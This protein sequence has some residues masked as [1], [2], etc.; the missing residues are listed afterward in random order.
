M[1]SSEIQRLFPLSLSTKDSEQ[2]QKQ[3]YVLSETPLIVVLWAEFLATFIS[4]TGAVGISL[5]FPFANLSTVAV[6]SGLSIGAATFA[7]FSESRAHTNPMA[8]VADVALKRV[9]WQWLFLYWLAQL[10]ACF[11]A[12]GMILTI[13]PNDQWSGIVPTFGTNT[14]YTGA[15][16]AEFIGSFILRLTLLATTEMIS[17]MHFAYEKRLELQNQLLQKVKRGGDAFKEPIAMAL[18]LSE[19]HT[20]NQDQWNRVSNALSVDLIMTALTVLFA[21]I[22]GNSLFNPFR[23]LAAA[24]LVN[25]WNSNSWVYYIGPI[26]GTLLSIVFYFP[27]QY[28]RTKIRKS[29]SGTFSHATIVHDK[30]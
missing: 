28:V 22:S 2:E 11:A 29:K 15:V 12:T 1:E 6:G 16:M 10:G 5:T 13:L 30:D 25:G 27:I 18:L 8:T 21:P 20:S 19:T 23:H 7:F 4:I 3:D 14:G 26:G 9:P 24:S 17:D